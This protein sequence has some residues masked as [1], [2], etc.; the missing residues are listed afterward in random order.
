M[1]A[2]QST[3]ETWLPVVGYE[4]RYEVSNLGRVRSLDRYLR[5]GKGRGGVRLLPGRIMAANTS[6]DGRPRIR[7]TDDGHV[8]TTR[9]VHQIVAAAFIGARPDGT[10]VCHNNGNP[11]DNRVENLRYDTHLA[12]MR[13][14]MLH[15]TTKFFHTHC[16]R[17]HELTP[18]NTYLNGRTRRC[19][20]CRR[21][22]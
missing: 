10:E 20:T 13:D 19:R 2:T 1:Q 15:G 9:L 12:N 16:Q 7:L 21:D 11:L 22:R 6:A 14:A 8:Q 5:C 3:V 4:G 17:G 18:E